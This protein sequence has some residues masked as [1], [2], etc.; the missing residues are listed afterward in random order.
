[1]LIMQKNKSKR[2]YSAITDLYPDDLNFSD[3]EK[4]FDVVMNEDPD[5]YD[6]YLPKLV[7]VNQ[8]VHY[9]FS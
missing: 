1:M 6:E 8:I 3:D 4:E 2:L 7:Y 5:S 9:S